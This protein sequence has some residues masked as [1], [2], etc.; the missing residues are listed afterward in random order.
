MIKNNIK[1]VGLGHNSFGGWSV[2]MLKNMSKA[3]F[4]SVVTNVSNSREMY[5]GPMLSSAISGWY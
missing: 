5:Y 2:N 1:L 4:K 3:T